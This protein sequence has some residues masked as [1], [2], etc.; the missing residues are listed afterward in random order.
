MNQTLPLAEL[1]TDYPAAVANGTA[2]A[3]HRE[4]NSRGTTA[5]TLNGRVDVVATA[6][7]AD[8]DASE[9]WQSYRQVSILALTSLLA[10][11]LGGVVFFE[12]LLAIIPLLSGAMA[13]A[14]WREIRASDGQRSGAPAA[15][16]AMAISAGC[17]FGGLGWHIY[18]YATE[19]PAG[20]TRLSYATLQPD[21]RG[22]AAW[23]DTINALDGQ[24]VFIKGF[25]YPGNRKSNIQAFILCRDKGDCCFGG[26]P[27]ITDRVLIQLS[28]PQ[29]IDLSD[30]MQKFYGTFRVNRQPAVDASGDVLFVLDAAQK[31]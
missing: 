5:A 13:L 21:E 10:A 20:F 15:Y 2:G 12:P 25:M 11:I 9:E 18:D 23:T 29:G 24:P 4:P 6:A 31:R 8:L 3:L 30:G 27:K 1:S 17:L 26:N 28:D 19:V 14:A 7:P 22:T 16:A